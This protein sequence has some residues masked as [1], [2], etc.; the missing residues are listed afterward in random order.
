[1]SM[2][3]II[4]NI[5]EKPKTY[6]ENVAY[7][8]DNANMKLIRRYIEKYYRK[9]HLADINVWTEWFDAVMNKELMQNKA[10][11]CI[12][13]FHS[14]TTMTWSTDEFAYDEGYEIYYVSL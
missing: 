9:E 11:N 5:N 3:E 12:V 2:K 10:H 6:D 8:V 7:L 1:M 13:Y 4:F 14:N